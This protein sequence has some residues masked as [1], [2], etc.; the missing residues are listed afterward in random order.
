MGEEDVRD[1]GSEA[2]DKCEGGDGYGDIRK[3]DID[4]GVL[5][6]AYSF[7]V[8]SAYCRIIWS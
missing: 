4:P 1:G 8:E 2:G 7:K 5:R 3:L 6:L